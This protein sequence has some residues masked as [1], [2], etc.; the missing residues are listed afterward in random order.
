MAKTGSPWGKTH[1]KS[2]IEEWLQV[3]QKFKPAKVR[4]SLLFAALQ[5]VVTEVKEIVSSKASHDE[6]DTSVPGMLKKKGVL[7]KVALE[8]VQPPHISKAVVDASV[9][10]TNAKGNPDRVEKPTNVTQPI[11][12]KSEMCQND[13][14]PKSTV[15]QAV[16]KPSWQVKNGFSQADIVPDQLSMRSIDTLALLQAFKK[17][18]KGQRKIARRSR[19]TAEVSRVTKV[20]ARGG[21]LSTSNAQAVNVRVKD[22]G[23]S[24][25]S[26]SGGSLIHAATANTS[27]NDAD[28]RGSM[29]TTENG[30][31]QVTGSLSLQSLDI[32]NLSSRT[33]TSPDQSSLLSMD[34]QAKPT[35]NSEL[36]SRPPTPSSIIEWRSPL[37]EY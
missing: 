34:S 5:E 25:P 28:A 23:R 4:P 21:T 17:Q 12:I 29:Q 9:W 10:K 7:H 24:A 26:R 8:Y 3:R 32:L 36:V 2:K 15:Q 6:V 22:E 19:S 16:E 30:K 27:L 37:T 13:A 14:P 20:D 1:S 11:A 18:R 31:S 35:E 33:G